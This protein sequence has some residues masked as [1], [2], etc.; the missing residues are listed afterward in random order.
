MTV[1][2]GYIGARLEATAHPL[3]A[4]VFL[5]LADGK[6]VRQGMRVELAVSTVRPEEYGYLLGKVNYVAPYPVSSQS[7]LFQLKSQELVNN[8]S[9]LGPLI[10]VDVDLEKEPNNFS[11]FKWTSQSGPHATLSNG[12]FSTANIVLGEQRPIDLVLPIFKEE[13]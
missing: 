11:G 7:L 2:D 12:T 4:I 3:Q 13:K 9:N 5:S 8:L 1:P 6:Q 10:K